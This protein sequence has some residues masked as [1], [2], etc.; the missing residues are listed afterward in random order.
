MIS[1]APGE[2]V[3]RGEVSN[4]Y[5]GMDSNGNLLTY[6]SIWNVRIRVT[7]SRHARMRTHRHTRARITHSLAYC[8]CFLAHSV[9]WSR[10]LA[11]CLFSQH[12]GRECRVRVFIL[13]HEQDVGLVHTTFLR[14]RSQG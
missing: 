10:L 7:H 4:R 13:T 5:I 11:V 3:L 8:P 1:V 12:S 2:I 6:V 14:L 9:D